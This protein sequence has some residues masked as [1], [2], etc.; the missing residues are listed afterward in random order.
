M[1]IVYKAYEESLNRYVALK[2]LGSHLAADTTF[3]ER[4]V[5]EAQSAAG[6]SHPNIVQIYAIGEDDGRHYFAM[7]YVSGTNLREL[8]SRRGR[9]ATD[10]AEGVIL[11][12]ASGLQAAHER[13]II[14]RDI[15]PANLILDD[16]GLVKIA[17]FGLALP[18]DSGARLTATGKMLG[19]PGYLSP[20]QCRG[21]AV[22]HRTDIYSLGVTWFEALT[23]KIPFSADSP[24]ALLRKIVD[25]A[26][27]DIRELNPEVDEAA[28]GILQRMMAK[29]PGQRYQSCTEL[30]AELDRDL[31]ARRARASVARSGAPVDTTP[32]TRSASGSDVLDTEPTVVVSSDV[33]SWPS[34][35]GDESVPLAAAEPTPPPSRQRRTIAWVA[36]ALVVVAV[37][38]VAGGAVVVAKSGLIGRLA[39]ARSARPSSASSPEPSTGEI[40][41]PGVDGTE[42]PAAVAAEPAAARDAGEPADVNVGEPVSRVVAQPS[43]NETQAGSPQRSSGADE[44]SQDADSLEPVPGPE[45]VPPARGVVV[46][47]VGESLLAGEAESYLEEVLGRSGAELVDERSLPELTGLLADGGPPERGAAREALRPHARFVLL[48]RIEYLG[49]RQIYYLGTPDVVYQARIAA[50]AVDLSDGS[51]IGPP[52]SERVEYTHLTAERV[53]R[54]ALRPWARSLRESVR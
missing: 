18:M 42:P 26:P 53:A 2:V 28:R 44:V 33:E 17:D 51:R 1:G 12:A 6:L 48:V 13:G 39:A 21:E 32:A 3:V 36:A 54:E 29:E 7:E 46:A 4:F 41:R 20:E 19:S 16:R 22:D 24:L 37:L 8:I 43:G 10:E 34:D 30:I 52:L 47:A 31:A 40:A 50:T 25:V 14:H 38:M 15:K 35:R 9:L 11:Q 5:R 23:G 49:E 27:P 45:P